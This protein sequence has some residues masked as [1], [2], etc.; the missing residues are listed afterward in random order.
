MKDQGK[1][2]K[3]DERLLGAFREVV[4]SPYRD[5]TGELKKKVSRDL[6][7][8]IVETLEP[9]LRE[10]FRDCIESMIH[11]V[12]DR[13]GIIPNLCFQHLFSL[14]EA[15]FRSE[16]F[17]REVNTRELL[18]KILQ[19]GQNIYPLMMP[20]IHYSSQKVRDSELMK[21]LDSNMIIMSGDIIEKGGEKNEKIS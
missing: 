12:L 10:Q 5:I 2:E 17:S 8:K 9:R 13:F 3:A 11:F 1:R 18:K 14:F 6:T 19:S 20:D 7:L 15:K 4:I 16:N 21:L